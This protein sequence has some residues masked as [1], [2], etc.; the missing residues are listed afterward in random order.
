MLFYKKYKEIDPTNVRNLITD[1]ISLLTMA[2]IVKELRM[3]E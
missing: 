2:V 3:K 1:T